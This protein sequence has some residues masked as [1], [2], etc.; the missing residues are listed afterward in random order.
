MMLSP[1]TFYGTSE[2]EDAGS[3]LYESS[4]C[5]SL[6]AGILVN[7]TALIQARYARYSASRTFIRRKDNVEEQVESAG[8]GNCDDRVILHRIA[9]C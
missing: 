7:T 5:A 2:V 4:R 1:R 6:C 8:R 3:L 9:S